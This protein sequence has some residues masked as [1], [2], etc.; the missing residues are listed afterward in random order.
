MN[1]KLEVSNNL[2]DINFP[3]SFKL[4]PLA[5]EH[6]NYLVSFKVNESYLNFIAILNGHF[7]T[8]D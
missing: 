2:N 8:V 7:R 3:V 5:L 1:D 6:S 4:C